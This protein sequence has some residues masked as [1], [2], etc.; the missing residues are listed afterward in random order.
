[1]AADMAVELQKQNVACVSLWPGPAKTELIQE[2]A[3]DKATQ[4][5]T[6]SFG[7]KWKAISLGDF[8]HIKST[9]GHLKTRPACSDLSFDQ[10]NSENAYRPACKFDH[11]WKETKVIITGPCWYKSPEAGRL[12]LFRTSSSSNFTPTPACDHFLTVL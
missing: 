5:E 6:V 1:M 10:S 11:E 3:R 4:G 2:W 12:H 7:M 8:V 9:L